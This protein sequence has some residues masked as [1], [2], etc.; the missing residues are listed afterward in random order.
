MTD[1]PPPEFDPNDLCEDEETFACGDGGSADDQAFDRIIGVIEDF[2]CGFDV[3]LLFTTPVAA[4]VA[5]SK[6]AG[7]DEG[8]SGVASDSDQQQ[9]LLPSLSA[10]P[11]DHDRHSYHK[12][13]VAKIESLLDA[14]IE[15]N[16]P[17]MHVSEVAAQIQTRIDEVGEEIWEFVQQGC[18]DY[19]SFL[20]LW[21]EY[22]P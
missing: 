17:G 19:V 21:K 3:T 14:H 2:M 22:R 10:V 20:A 5:K 12:A 9:L 13:F 4:I 8:R 1:T 7:G 11:S 6:G 18:M 16:M 15:K